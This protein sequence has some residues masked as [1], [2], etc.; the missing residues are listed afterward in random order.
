[1]PEMYS[2]T[3]PPLAK[4]WDDRLP[5]GYDVVVIGS[6]YGGAI[7]AARLATA[8]WPGTKP[9]ICIL[10]RGKEWLPGEFPD[11]LV[12]G[13]QQVR[14]FN[15][16]G[17]YDF[18]LGTD[19]GAL[20]GSGLGGTSLINANVAIRPDNE[21]F[22]QSRWPQAI[23]EARD[24]GKL[25]QY[26]DRVQATLQAGPHPEGMKLSKARALKQGADR[27]KG[28]NFD[29]LNLAVNFTTEGRNKWGIEQRKCINE[30]DCSTGC[31]VGA[32]NTLDT[33]YLAIAKSAGAHI[34]TQVEVKHIEKSAA[35]GYNLFYQRRKD[36]HNQPEQGMLTAKRLIVL[37]AGAL[38]STEILLR[39]KD[40]GL[41]LPNTVGSR[42]SGN[43]DFFGIS[44]NSD[45][46]TDVLGWGAYPDSERARRLQPQPGQLLVPGPTIVGRIKYK[47]NK[48]L[49]KRITIEDFSFP[50]MLVD[51]ARSIFVWLIGRDTDL[52][53]FRDNIKE[54]ERK[55]RDIG[56]IDPQ[57]E[58]GALNHTLLYL[59]MG[60]DDGAGRI[61]LDSGRVKIQWPKVGRQKI[62][63]K[64]N[65]QLLAHA[66]SLGATFIKNPLWRF[67]P[68]RTLM[69]VHPLGGCPMGDNPAQ[70]V[71][72][73]V[74]QVFDAEGNL[75][76]G[77]YVAD[78][79]VIPTPLG[80]NPFLTISAI[81][82][83]IAEHLVTKL[84]GTPKV[85]DHL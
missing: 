16:L 12:K 11:S 42:F 43:G 1:M 28:A 13:A 61:V 49:K 66:K 22:D 55:T 25:S 82:E 63:K 79:S 38:G 7:T 78:G 14:T 47:T 21:V 23:R 84:G 27:V 45:V 37:A 77:L 18:H 41:Q 10:E 52:F 31:N 3:R 83:R 69:T 19:I 76:D 39:S 35:E 15:P 2:V 20:V 36:A 32:K 62:F 17:L 58:E 68:S 70:S 85:I 80:V 56:G 26:F 67:T 34:F 48:G 51:A 74:G 75:H 46:R 60:Q 50:L 54:F 40:E 8:H 5:D 71:A 33:N 59:V 24:S 9:S 65:K 29:L 6:G 57:L 53:D 30:G 72:N 73:D 44:Y 64:M 4:N 81:A